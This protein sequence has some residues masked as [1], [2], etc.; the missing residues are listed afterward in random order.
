MPFTDVVPGSW[1]CGAVQY[2]CENG[3]MN[4]TGG[5]LFSP[6]SITSRAMIVTILHRMEGA[7]AASASSFTDIAAGAYYENAVNWAAEN[8]IVSGASKTSFLPDDPVTREQLAVILY[9]Y[10]QYKSYDVTGS[11]DLSAYTDAAQI[12]ACATDA[13]Q[14]A[15]ENGLITGN[16]STTLNPKG[17]TTRAEAATVLMRFCQN[18]AE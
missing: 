16:T 17:H 18:I 13:M 6:N 10:A 4:G 7:P 1:Y 15:N 8:G 11:T 5:R 12:D 14:W 2:V 9:R 3:M